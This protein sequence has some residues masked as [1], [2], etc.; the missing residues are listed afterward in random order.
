MKA[1]DARNIA[2]KINCERTNGSLQR[3]LDIIMRVSKEGKFEVRVAVEDPKVPVLL[4]Q[5]GYGVSKLE[6]SESFANA[7]LIKW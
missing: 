5:L 6:E 1:S 4:N 7:H 2:E 3:V